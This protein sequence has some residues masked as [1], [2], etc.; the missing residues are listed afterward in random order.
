MSLAEHVCACV[1]SIKVATDR[2]HQF[3]KGLSKGNE[4]VAK[5][6]A[7]VLQVKAEVEAGIQYLLKKR[8]QDPYKEFVPRLVYEASWGG[9][10]APTFPV[11]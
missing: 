4:G 9:K 5:G 1:V 2:Q 6:L 7:G 10:P 11:P 8:E 3:E